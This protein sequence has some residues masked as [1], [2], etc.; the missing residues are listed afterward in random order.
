[1]IPAQTHLLPQTS[2]PL[3]KAL[4]AVGER[5]DEIGI[6]WQAYLDPLRAPVHFLPVLAHAH[7]VDIWNPKWPVHHQ[8]R[9]IAD[10]IYH[11]RIKGT[12]AGLE[13]YAGIV[14]SEIIRAIRPPGTFFLSGGM[15]DE[16]R[17]ALADRMPQIRIYTRALR[18]S[19]G[20][21]LFLSARTYSA[22]GASFVA[23]SKA[24]ERMRPRI[25][26]F[27]A[28]LEQP[29]NVEEVTDIIPGLGYALFERALL[30][31][32]RRAS[33]TYLGGSLR[34]WVS[35][36]HNRSV[37]AFRRADGAPSVIRYGMRP[38]T[39]QPEA[40]YTASTA[41]RAAFFGRPLH[42]RYWSNMHS[43]TRVFERIVIW[44]PEMVPRRRG[45]SYLG[46]SRFGVAPFTAELVVHAPSI[47][48][49]RAF[50]V[51]GFFGN[52]FA[53]S[54]GEKYRET[55][56]ALRAAKSARDTILIN[57]KTF[58]SPQAGQLIVA[59]TP[60]IAGRLLRS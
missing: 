33:V 9:V 27:D 16:Q 38:A 8:R 41:G 34:F 55:L 59:G 51:G 36:D 30:R 18:S 12:L 21:R 29:I 39:V 52:Y 60:F 58:R 57:T 44:D 1:M 54:D 32:K 35:L 43:E 14:G 45:A 26:F 24:A 6:D 3:E 11:H 56:R 49:R 46:V 53:A 50:A 10:A 28:G 20:Q 19:A 5:T 42:R 4:A 17:A 37:A 15:S 48:P 47:R 7:S 23:D 2:L 22:L 25:T 40:Q 31:R 13:A